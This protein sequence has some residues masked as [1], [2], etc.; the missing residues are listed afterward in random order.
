LLA[1]DAQRGAAGHEQ[2]AARRR[3]EQPAQLGGGGEDLLEVVDH[4][5]HLLAGEQ[6]GGGL[7]RAV[8]AVLEGAQRL[9]EGG[10]DALG[11]ADRRER[12]EAAA[13]F[14]ARCGASGELEGEARLPDPARAREREQADVGVGEQGA[15]RGEILLAAQ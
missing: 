2:L 4:E 15:R 9:G 12:D 8:A 3:G 14:E 1:R 6:L 11:V 13:V 5:Q 7:E 10:D